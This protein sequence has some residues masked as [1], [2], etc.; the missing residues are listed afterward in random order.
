MNQ[1]IWKNAVR[2]ITE[3]LFKKEVER[4]LGYFS[5]RCYHVSFD[6]LTP[7]EQLAAVMQ[8]ATVFRE[9]QA[10]MKKRRAKV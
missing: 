10:E 1:A 9:M 2:P 4:S 8:F 6:A 3:E 5:L 7:D